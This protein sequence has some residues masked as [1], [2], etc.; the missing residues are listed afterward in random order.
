MISRS[1]GGA[2]IKRKIIEIDREQCDGCGLCAEACH[3][4]AIGMADGKAAL[5]RDDYCDG[6]GNS[7]PVCSAGA[8]AFIEREAE[9]YNEEEVKKNIQ[10]QLPR[11]PCPGSN[12]HSIRR[13]SVA[14]PIQTAEAASELRQWPIQIKLVP[15]NAPYLDGT[16]LLVAADCAAYARANFHAEYMRGKITLH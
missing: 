11:G 6:L 8:I 9:T 2:T 16:N 10:K 5:L 1:Q 7:L 15:V 13:E 12:A 14:A 3:E 4:G